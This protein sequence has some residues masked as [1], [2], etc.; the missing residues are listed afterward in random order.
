[1]YQMGRNR[2]EPKLLLRAKDLGTPDVIKDGQLGNHIKLQWRFPGE[3]IHHH[4][5]TVDFPAPH[6]DVMMTCGRSSWQPL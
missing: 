1:M 2:F 4:P 3:I 5:S 6:D